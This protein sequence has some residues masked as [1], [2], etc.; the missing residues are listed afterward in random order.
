M[1]QPDVKPKTIKLSDENIGENICDLDSGKKFLHIMPKAWSIK[2]KKNDELYYSKI[3][4]VW[5][6]K[7]LLRKW[8]ISHRLGENICK[9]YTW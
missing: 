9:S 2:L 5:L 8:K 6:Q 7:I 4:I 1:D 3:K